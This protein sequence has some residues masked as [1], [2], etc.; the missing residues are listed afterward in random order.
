MLADG[1]VI[2]RALLT[3]AA[4]LAAFGAHTFRDAFGADNSPEDVAAYLASTYGEPQQRAEIANPSIV[5]LLGEDGGTTVAFAQ[6]RNGDSPACVMLPTPVE[7]WRFYVDRR[8][9]G[10]GVAYRLMDAA[11]DAA[12][13]LGGRSVWLSVWER[14]P[15]A[16][17]FYANCGF[18]DVG[19][20][21]FIVGA[22]RQTD[23]VMA[24]P[25][26]HSSTV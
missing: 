9:H 22:D 2:R 11:L 16:I 12:R 23:R 19:S 25:I 24:R 10:L 20:K 15:R 3:D 18:A 8:W 14:N 13:A 6:V 7:L 17:A 1:L 26:E 5:T 21:L 4:A